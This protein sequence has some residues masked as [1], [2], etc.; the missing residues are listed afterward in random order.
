[1]CRSNIHV[2]IVVR[3]RAKYML[4][5]QNVFRVYVTDS[6]VKCFL[7]QLASVHYMKKRNAMHASVCV[8]NLCPERSHSQAY[9]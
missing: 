8:F 9:F 3:V 1:M 7:T 4:Y 5:V 6:L 2:F